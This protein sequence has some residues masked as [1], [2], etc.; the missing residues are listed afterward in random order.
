MSSDLQAIIDKILPILHE[1]SVRRAS[2][3]GSS[4]RGE[5]GPQS[6]IDILVDLPEGKSLF[7]L[8]DLKVKLEEALGR[9]VD[10]VEYDALKPRLKER[11][12]SEQ[13]PIL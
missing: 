12:L 7:D 11:V 10:V 2:L 1:A 6:D 4:V 8:V 9:K 13:Q 3:F 5:A